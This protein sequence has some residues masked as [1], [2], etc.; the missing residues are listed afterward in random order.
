MS[1]SFFSPSSFL[2]FMQ[3]MGGMASAAKQKRTR[4]Y[5]LFAKLEHIMKQ[6]LSGANIEKL[7]ERV[8]VA[9]GFQESRSK[10]DCY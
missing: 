7:K 1:I 6:V 8:P 5:A 10:E 4:D 3:G 9:G 2:F